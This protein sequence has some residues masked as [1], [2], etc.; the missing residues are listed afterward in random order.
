MAISLLVDL[1]PAVSHMTFNPHVPIERLAAY[2]QMLCNCHP[3][4]AFTLYPPSAQPGFLN[5]IYI[6]IA[7]TTVF[8]STSNVASSMLRLYKAYEWNYCQMFFEL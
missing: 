1:A 5:V 4:A 6:S 2:R 3:K 8:N 7:K